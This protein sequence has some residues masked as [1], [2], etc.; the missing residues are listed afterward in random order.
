[1]IERSIHELK[2][3]LSRDRGEVGVA[4]ELLAALTLEHS[5]Y[6]VEVAH[7][8]RRGDLVVTDMKT[9]ECWYIEVKTAR[10]GKDGGYHFTLVKDG[11]TDHRGCD[12][13]VLMCVMKSGDF[14][15]FVVPTASVEHRKACCIT[16]FPTSYRGV[17]AQYRQRMN[18]IRL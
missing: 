2:S 11:H 14:V 7:T 8:L 16:S 12:L 3:M 18:E 15:A 13:V 9:G 6:R 1:M 5:G 4:G 10:R 17:L